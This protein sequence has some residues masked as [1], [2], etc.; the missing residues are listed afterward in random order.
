M[1]R[2]IHKRLRAIL[3][4]K[5]DSLPDGRRSGHNLSY[6]LSDAL[7]CA[8][9]IFFFQHPSAL[10]FQRQMQEKRRRNNIASIRGGGNTVGHA[11]KDAS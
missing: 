4:R 8:F 1:C 11:D 3:A 9:C 2:G 5:E 7:I 10:A 6:R